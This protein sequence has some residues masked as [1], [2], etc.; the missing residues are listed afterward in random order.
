MFMKIILRIV[1]LSLL[2]SVSNLILL[3]Y[4]LSAEE[5]F[6]IDK[7][8]NYGKLN[9]GF[10]YYIRKNE[11]PKDKLYIKLIIKAGS[12]MEESN[13]LGLA[14]LLEHMAF[15][16]SKN[17]PKNALDQFMSSIGLD[18]G[19]H[20]NASTSQLYTSYE[21]EIP[22]DSSEN[23]KNTIEIIADISNNL[24]L[25]G[26]A[27]ERER[28]IVEEEWRRKLGA[29]KRYLDQLFKYIYKDS[30][31]LERKPI[32]KIDV[33]RNFKYSEAIDYYQKWYQPNLMG[34]FVTGDVN[35]NE[36]KNLIIKNFSLFKNKQLK[37]PEY[38]IPDF[39]NNQF[40]KYQDE[41]TK[42]LSFS[43]WEKDKFKKLNNL[44]NYREHKIN[45]LVQEIY[46]R[47][48]DE[49]LEKNEISFISSGMG[50]YQVSDL[51][52]YKIFSTNLNEGK[53]KEGIIDFLTIIKQI[54]KFGFLN[55]ELNL[56][57]RNHLLNLKQ[58]LLE[59]KTRESE[60]YVYEYQRHFLYDEMISSP[61]DQIKYTEEIISTITIEDLNNHFIKYT[62]ANNQIIE[63]K[64]PSFI[65]NLPG[66]NEI[67]KF[68]E[69]VNKKEIK[70]H[71]F[72]LKEVELIKKN[73]TGSKIIK[74][75]KFPKTNV[76]K[77]T[78]KNGPD[79]Y[80]KKTDFKKDEIIIR[81]YSSG[82]YS[83][84][85][86]DLLPS[87]K[88]SSNILNQADIGELSLIEKDNLYPTSFVDLYP[89]INEDSEG[90]KGH[91]NKEHIEDMF[92][93]LYLNFT[94]LRVKQR[95][96]DIFKKNK[97]SQ[98]NIDKKNPKYLNQL[99]FRSKLFNDHPRTR[100]PTDQFYK[101]INLKA[102]KQFYNDRFKDGANFNFVIVGDFEFNEIEPL[103]EKYIGS[104][105]QVDRQDGYIDNGIRYNL[106]SEEISYEQQQPK[107]ANV[108]RLY[109]KKFKNTFKE[110][111][112]AYLLFS[113]IDKL[114]FDEIREK[115]NLVYSI[116]T[117]KYFDQYSPIE[118][119][120]FYINYQADPKNVDEINQKINSI[121]KK[122]KKGDFDLKIFK[123]KKLTLINDYKTSLESNSTWLNTIYN[124]DYNDL[125]LE[126]VMYLETIINSITIREISLLANKY[127]D[128]IYFNDV[129]LISE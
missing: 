95:H 22:S 73:L 12:V 8:I 68:F 7:N 44:N 72:E 93:L 65:K 110:R 103:I 57:K 66:E 52:E 13:Q 115:N 32:G 108:T 15:N 60:S 26:E 116:S 50:N 33:I 86:D 104:L 31:L 107:N 99:E 14:H 69:E 94:D 70:P 113:I 59:Q 5:K 41:E 29:D 67:K 51:D 76:V 119:I 98:Y 84:A 42:S 127:F 1:V 47:R 88:Y 55:S 92:K 106:T 91:S 81:G 53:I 89:F 101:K 126:R 78:L 18:I 118:L 19:S 87:A 125:N 36:I 62:K 58:N 35:V 90:V 40:F 2:L 114:F 80:L 74:K 77:L 20:Y 9:N 96:I 34:I 25:E 39:K 11:K 109:F 17:F 56:A 64:G 102:V 46:Y 61:E 123:D 43:I 30:L 37:L 129:K 79:V 128:G 27:F 83:Q 97:I 6:P 38:G 100:Y 48:V 112:K 49:L 63:I 85:S 3:N 45:G 54:E 122:V 105:P 82:G 117:N 4:P 120:S 28:K 21:F 16:G 23:I 10:T 121:L 75:V 111:Y 24:S 124:A 71:V